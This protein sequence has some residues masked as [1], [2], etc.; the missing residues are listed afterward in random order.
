MPGNKISNWPVLCLDGPSG[1][2]KGA[3]GQIIADKLGWHFLDS[4]A[5]YRVL[6]LVAQQKGFTPADAQQLRQ[7]TKDLR[8]DFESRP[9]DVPLVFVDGVEVSNAIRTEECGDFA[10]RLA[11]IPEIREGLIQFQRNQCRAPGL[12]AD[13]RDMGTV[14]FP[15]A[16]TKV[17]LKATAEVR[18]RRRYNQLMQ[19]GLGGNLP[20]LIRTIQERDE[21]DST[22]AVSPLIP[23]DDAHVL[24]TSELTIPEVVKHVLGLLAEQRN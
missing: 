8:L 17:F 3:V 4:G 21:R 11:A 7:L 2:G 16:K 6:A 23:S 15:D 5:I 22:R 1:V 9:G 13:G 18:A 19:K 14:V 24:D 10:S 12:V 20:R